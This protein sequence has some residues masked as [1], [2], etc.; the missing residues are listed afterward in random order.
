MKRRHLF[1][2]LLTIIGALTFGSN[3]FAAGITLTPGG[4]LEYWADDVNDTS[5]ANTIVV[6]K[7][8]TAG[9]QSWVKIQYDYWITG[10][11]YGDASLTNNCILEINYWACPATAVWIRTFKGDDSISVDPGINVKMLLEGG[12]GSDTITGGD[13]HDEIWAACKFEPADQCY[14]FSDTLNGGGGDDTIY[15]GNTTPVFGKAADVLHGGPGD[16]T[17][18]GAQGADQ[19][20]GDAGKDTAWYGWRANP[21]T[22]SL[23]DTANDGEAG[24][25]DYIH[26]DIEAIQGGVGKDSLSGGNTD[27]TLKGGPGDDTL[28]GYGGNDYLYGEEGS[29]LLRPGTGQDH[30]YGG[31]DSSNSCCTFDTATY[32]E[33][34]NPVNLS[35]DGNANDGEAGEGDYIDSDIENLVGG[36]NNDTLI[37]DGRGN[38]LTGNAGQDTLLG[39]GSP[40]EQNPGAGPHVPDTLNGGPDNDSLDGGPA[41]SVGDKI[42][43]GVGTDTLTYASRSD[44][45][46]V[47]LDKTAGSEGCERRAHSRDS[48]QSCRA[49]ST[50]RGLRQRRGRHLTQPVGW[51]VSGGSSNVRASMT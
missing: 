5:L 46:K 38:T 43:G 45:V 19:L 8:E 49:V 34:W 26:S 48:R 16:D 25:G 18:E 7:A 29:D 31:D 36:S 15:G 37:G 1:F 40:Q 3:A 24:E 17:L 4:V 39:L 44:D 27:D 13:E 20:W 28:N 47:Y 42:D 10:P 11:V 30:L 41:G 33:R 51:S 14:G 6:K 21:I 32:S 9:F 12:G 2:L 23:D 35:L 22:A 50:L